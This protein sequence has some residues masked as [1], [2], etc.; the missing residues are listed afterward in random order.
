MTPH[1]AE[2]EIERAVAPGALSAP[3]L[4]ALANHPAECPDCYALFVR[5]G[6]RVAA[7]NSKAK[8]PQLQFGEEKTNL[9][10]NCLNVQASRRSTKFQYFSRIS[11]LNLTYVTV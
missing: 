9:W 1:P 8:E 4:D 5:V 11:I 3:E 6:G 7:G 2:Q 10:T